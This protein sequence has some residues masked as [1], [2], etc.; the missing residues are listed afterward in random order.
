MKNKFII[1]SLMIVLALSLVAFQNVPKTQFFVIGYTAESISHFDYFIA[2]KQVKINSRIQMLSYMN[3]LGYRC[4][5]MS[6]D[7]YRNQGWEYY[8]F[9]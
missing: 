4:V 6:F 5:T 1:A 2:G 8:I 7:T 9:E 3:S